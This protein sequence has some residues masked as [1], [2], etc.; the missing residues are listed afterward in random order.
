MAL[1]RAGCMKNKF[2]GQP[3]WALGT[4]EGRASQEVS[5]KDISKD[6]YAG[7]S[8]LVSSLGSRKTS[9]WALPLKASQQFA[10]ACGQHAV[11]PLAE[12]VPTEAASM[13][14]IG[15]QCIVLQ[16]MHHLVAFPI[17]ATVRH[18]TVFSTKR[19]AGCTAM[20]NPSVRYKHAETN[21]F[22]DVCR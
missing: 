16:G 13:I 8:Y 19:F 2:L 17:S 18:T 4:K 12:L 7:I 9:D 3:G 11:V 1:I 14:L 5:F 15:Y 6:I 20:R 21:G 10:D 22:H